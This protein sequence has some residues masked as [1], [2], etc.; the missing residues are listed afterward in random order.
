MQRLGLPARRELGVRV[1]ADANWPLG[2]A[3]RHE[4]GVRVAQDENCGANKSLGV[5]RK[6]GPSTQQAIAA[7]PCARSAQ[8]VLSVVQHA[9]RITDENLV[10][11]P[12]HS[13]SA[14]PATTLA[15]SGQNLANDPSAVAAALGAL[16]RRALDEVPPNIK[17]QVGMTLSHVPAKVPPR[18]SQPVEPSS[19][20]FWQRSGIPSS[21]A[22]LG[23]RSAAVLPSHPHV[24]AVVATA[25]LAAEPVV[26][27]MVV[28]EMYAELPHEDIDEGDEDDPIFCSEYVDEIFTYLHEKEAQERI[29]HTYMARQRDINGT[30][31]G[32]LVDWMTEVHLKFKLLNDTLFLSVLIVDKY[33]SRN[34]L[35][36]HLLQLLGVT[37]MLIA[38]KVEEAYPVT[39][40]DLAFISDNACATEKIRV[41][42]RKVL[43]GVNWQ[44]NTPSPLCF[45][46]RFSKAGRANT[47][48]HTMSKYL[49][50]LSLLDHRLLEHLP[51]L[52]AAA[53]V[54]LAR[55]F[56]A[57]K[58][59]WNATLQFYTKY[60]E[61]D[62]RPC[63]QHLKAA[64]SNARS[65]SNRC[66]FK[67]YS[68]PSLFE[69][70]LLI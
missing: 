59:F 58:P 52:V 65:A 56:Y 22:F 14:K 8:R 37:A 39:V 3:T 15:N 28:D 51:S 26:E 68:S 5:L 36:R 30:M 9:A 47:T 42:E 44:L 57:V 1:V 20:V 38:S 32:I 41:F 18:P 55:R 69:V 6:L 4:L 34:Q 50:E 2:H 27:P 70:A 60:T 16:K 24:S 10:T 31:R 62:V 17:R 46:R 19:A 21:A 67:K 63:A 29:D 53:A 13:G 61:D 64:F 25:A 45:L 35:P 49:I 11:K 7:N 12:L 23:T 48:M 33:L 54:Y 43:R 40:G 66:I